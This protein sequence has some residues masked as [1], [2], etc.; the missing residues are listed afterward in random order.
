[1]KEGKLNQINLDYKYLD[2]SRKIY[3]ELPID[4]LPEFGCFIHPDEL[5]HVLFVGNSLLVT[6]NGEQLTDYQLK[7]W[8]DH[9]V[10]VLANKLNYDLYPRLWRY[11]DFNKKTREIEEFAE[12]D[13]IYFDKLNSNVFI[14]KL[15]HRPICRLISWKVYSPFNNQ[16]I[17]DLTDKAIIHSHSGIIQA[18]YYLV[19]GQNYYISPKQYSSM[20]AG[21]VSLIHK[22][23]YVSGFDKANRI[24]EELKEVI[25][26]Q[27]IIDV[28]SA[29]GDGIVGGL[30]SSS[31][32]VGVL[33]ESIGTT[34]SATSAYFG[35]RIVEKQ[36]WIEEWFKTRAPYYK[37]V[38]LGNL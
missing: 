14:V 35:A 16:F 25:F 24:P 29:Y 32:S 18:Y 1:M 34:I 27:M 31:V 6:V 8:I 37:G 2:L 5:R 7:N 30:A 17:I 38:R 10:Y 13:N 3:P 23:D 4:K 28:M 33:S 21:N 26:N 20:Y 22:I 11:N 19:Q 12:Y 36:K 9:N 15:R